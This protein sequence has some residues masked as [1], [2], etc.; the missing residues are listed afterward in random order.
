MFQRQSRN[1]D[2]LLK[3]ARDSTQYLVRTCLKVRWFQ[4]K[5]LVIFTESASE[6]F[7]LKGYKITLSIPMK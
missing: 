1:Q 4:Q 3:I 2:D 6:I 5:K 7:T